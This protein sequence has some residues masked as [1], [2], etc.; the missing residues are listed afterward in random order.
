MNN[1][2]PPTHLAFR[3]LR[4]CASKATSSHSSMCICDRE[5]RSSE[6]SSS[7]ILHRE[8]A[9][10]VFEKRS[11]QLLTHFFK[12]F[13]MTCPHLH[14]THTEGHH[15]QRELCQANR[16]LYLIIIIK[17][18]QVTYDSF[19]Q[20]M[21][22]ILNMLI[23]VGMI[24]LNNILQYLLFIAMIDL[25]RTYDNTTS[26][27]YYALVIF[28]IYPWIKINLKV[29]IFSTVIVVCSYW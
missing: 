22:Y 9:N 29:L 6:P 14:Q 13:I 16:H 20:I 1:N 8:R 4:Y 17:E 11:S 18:L 5:S 19:S 25:S 15:L 2:E 27:I 28:M 26:L 7:V 23:C 3:L 21:S 12:F 10:K 24:L